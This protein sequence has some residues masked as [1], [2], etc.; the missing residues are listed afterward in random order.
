M[1]RI[2]TGIASPRIQDLTE[3]DAIYNLSGQKVNGSYK[4]LVIQNGKKKLVK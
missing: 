1:G 4:G 2:T 3:D